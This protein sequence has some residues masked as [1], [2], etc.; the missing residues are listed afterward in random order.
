M[1][2]AVQ[3]ALAAVVGV[4]IAR[5]FGR[6]AETDGFFAAYGVFVAVV[7]A[8]TAIRVTVLPRFARARAADRLSG[9]VLATGRAVS[10]VLVP[11]VLACIL[12]RE[13]LAALLTGF[14]PEE[15]RST[16]ATAL[17]WVVLAG[18]GQVLAGL[19]ASAFAALD[20]YVVPAVGYIAGSVAGLALILARVDGDGIVAVAWGIALNGAI[21]ALVPAALL[22]RRAARENVPAAALRGDGARVAER[23]LELGVGTAMPLALQVLYVICLPIAASSGVGAV[24]SLGYGYLL[25]SAVVAVTA[26]S[27]GLVTSVPLTRVG[28]VPASVARHVVASSWIALIATGATGGVFATAG[29]PIISSI[30]GPGYEAS[31]GAELGRV[32]VALVPWMVVTVGISLVFPLVFVDGAGSRLLAVAGSA[33]VVHVPLAFLGQEV[34]G[35]TGLALAL[36]VSTGIALVGMLHLLGAAGATLRGLAPVTAT[37]GVA[38]VAAYSVSDVLLPGVAAAVVG[39]LLYVACFVVIRPAG[40]TAAWRHLHRLG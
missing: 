27:I 30:L 18:A 9:D 19:L 29:S 17:P 36:A 34:A 6:D 25:G 33:I 35:L 7:L 10:V 22:A 38:A 32:V 1:A 21:A 37:V 4:I 14:G 24:T 40:L 20:D 2:L 5:E 12:A 15:A 26:S 28:L 39:T 11:I 13:P 23:L 31:L 3:T 16:A 8:A